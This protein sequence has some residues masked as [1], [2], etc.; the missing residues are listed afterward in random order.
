MLKT[1]DSLLSLYNKHLELRLQDQSAK[2][3]LSNTL[4]HTVAL[5][6][7]TAE[8]HNT[9]LPILWECKPLQACGSCGMSVCLRYLWP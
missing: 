1:L 7:D 4:I 5:G 8:S 3:I 6:Q 2:V 9:Y